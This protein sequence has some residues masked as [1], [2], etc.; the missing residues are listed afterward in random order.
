[1]SEL[2]RGF[3]ITLSKTRVRLNHTD[4]MCDNNQIG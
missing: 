1:M 3:E 4:Q 2:A